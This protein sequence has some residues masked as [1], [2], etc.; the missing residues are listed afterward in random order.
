[1][2]DKQQLDCFIY[3]TIS[4]VYWSLREKDLPGF[5]YTN[6]FRFRAQGII[7]YIIKLSNSCL[8]AI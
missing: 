8:G 4:I 7:Y 1:M 6:N 2:G 3:S 5:F